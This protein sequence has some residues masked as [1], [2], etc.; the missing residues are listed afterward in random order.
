MRA[1]SGTG[2]QRGNSHDDRYWDRLQRQFQACAYDHTGAYSELRI[3]TKSPERHKLERHF[4]LAEQT[5]E[6]ERYKNLRDRI[7]FGK[8]TKR[9]SAVL[10]LKVLG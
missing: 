8:N 1:N 10:E 7:A 9:L 3:R 5:M 6:T 4:E 2:R